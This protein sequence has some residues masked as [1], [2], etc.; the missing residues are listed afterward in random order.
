MASL[1]S[2]LTYV[3]VI[4]LDSNSMPQG[5]LNLAEIR[6]LR[7]VLD[8]DDLLSD[9]EI[10][11]PE[12]VVWEWSEHLFASLTARDAAAKK[13]A[14]QLRN[15]GLERLGPAQSFGTPVTIDA[16]VAAVELELERHGVRILRFLD[17]PAAAIGGLRDQVL[18]VGA[19]NRKGTAAGSRVKTGA[20]DSASLRLLTTFHGDSGLVI[21][22]ADKDVAAHFRRME[23]GAESP[24]IVPGLWELRRALSHL[25]PGAEESVAQVR[26]ALLNGLRG[27]GAVGEATLENGRVAFPGPDD[28]RNV[29]IA[30]VDVEN[31]LAVSDIRVS[32]QDGF[33]T[34]EARLLV[35]LQLD[36]V[37][38]D[39]RGDLEVINLTASAVAATA[40]V[41]ASR[42]GD[43]EWEVAV[44]HVTVD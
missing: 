13:A 19:G 33:A 26:E 4:G 38:E 42:V 34:A 40:Q 39:L 31:V 28:Y 7:K 29:I 6:R 15:A 22:S 21:V 43:R 1:E 11:V 5:R 23:P 2:K 32:R 3:A 14:K 17:A 36:G 27:R 30:V 20:A 25:F 12:P 24:V 35:E 10:C 37:M 16:V 44:D 18:Q 8:E 9:A 41:S